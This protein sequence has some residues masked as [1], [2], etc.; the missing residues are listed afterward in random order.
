MVRSQELA[1]YVKSL[2]SVTGG[3]DRSTSINFLADNS[4]ESLLVQFG[5]SEAV[6]AGLLKHLN[7]LGVRHR[8]DLQYLSAEDVCDRLSLALVDQRKFLCLLSSSLRYVPGHASAKFQSHKSF[9]DP[10]IN[11]KYF[12]E[13]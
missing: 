2:Y 6:K 4:L 5:L 9:Q 13:I 12:V 7:E 10:G 3:E 8:Y 11:Q 1:Q